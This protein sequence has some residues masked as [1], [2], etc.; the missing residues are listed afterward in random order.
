MLS[1]AGAITNR[2]GGSRTTDSPSIPVATGPPDA[3]SNSV[4]DESSQPS[5]RLIWPSASSESSFAAWAAPPISTE[6]IPSR[7]VSS[8]GRSLRRR[9]DRGCSGCSRREAVG[10]SAARLRPAW[11]SEGRRA[12][13]AARAARAASPPS[14]AASRCG[15]RR[16]ATI[17]A[18]TPS[19]TLLTKIRSLT[20]AR[21]IRRSTRSGQ[22]HRGHRPHRRDQARGRVR[23]GCACPQE[24]TT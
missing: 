22:R 23:G 8:R 24:R 4:A 20:K 7:P 5:K 15:R 13:R 3:T 10:S 9:G 2:S 11:Q 19:D 17:S 21:S 16:T 14:S 18:Y 1:A 12:S 6:T